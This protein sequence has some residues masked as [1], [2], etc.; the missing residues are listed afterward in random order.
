MRKWLFIAGAAALLATACSQNS[1]RIHTRLTQREFTTIMTELE[2][3]QP[4][5]RAAILQ[6]HRVTQAD[7]RDFVVKYSKYPA[8]LSTAFDT[9][10]AH[11]APGA[12]PPPATVPSLP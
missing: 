7:L 5:Q 6:K 9:L 8:S 1:P 4:G 10:Q 11:T 3:A 2:R 12:Q